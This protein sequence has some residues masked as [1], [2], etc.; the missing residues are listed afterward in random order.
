MSVHLPPSE[1]SGQ[2]ICRPLASCSKTQTCHPVLSSLVCHDS[3]CSIL[4]LH[5]KLPSCHLVRGNLAQG[6]RPGYLPLDFYSI[7]NALMKSETDISIQFSELCFAG[8]RDWLPFWSVILI[9]LAAAVTGFLLLLLLF[10]LVQ[11]RIKHLRRLRNLPSGEAVGK[12]ILHLQAPLTQ[13][14]T[15]G[16]SIHCMLG[17]HSGSETQRVAQCAA[18]EFRADPRARDV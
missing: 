5:N 4:L 17:G 16:W 9:A 18:S 8:H 12:K 2:G 11:R 1:H 10:V 13:F 14:L 15:S 3:C 6:F 7:E